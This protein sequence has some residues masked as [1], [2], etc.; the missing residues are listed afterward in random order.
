ML[1]SI[2]MATY[3]GEKYILKQLESIL[4]Q[5]RQP[6]EVIICDDA[7]SDAPT[8]IIRNFIIINQLENWQLEVNKQNVGYRKNFRELIAKAKGDCVFLSD[9]DDEWNEDKI[10][11]MLAVMENNPNI[12]TLNSA[13][14]LIDKT[15]SPIKCRLK[16]NR[17]NCN[18]FRYC[19]KLDKIIF[20]DFHS[21]AQHNVSPGCS[22]CIS[23]RA[24][25]V[26]IALY[27]GEIPHDYFLN[28]IASA[29]NG[30]AF[31]NETLVQYRQ[32]ENNVIGAKSKIKRVR[33]NSVVDLKARL[34]EEKMVAIQ[35]VSSYFDMEYNNQVIAS[36]DFF[37]N[38]F[39]FYQ[40]PSPIKLLKL[41]RT[42]E[43]MQYG[44]AKE[45]L[46]DVAYA[47]H[48]YKPLK[49]LRAKRLICF[50]TRNRNYR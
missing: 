19:G 41:Y 49:L 22:M 7:S 29:N 47:I 15:S 46:V 13:V 1:V 28:L 17:Y 11:R 24:K 44:E 16:K 34:M 39:S 26:F 38:M 12:W 37:H 23:Q 3:N 4:T 33:R 43:Y 18:F 45:K 31:L 20:F 30:C 5:T 21:I 40:N 25:N 35:K 6:D 50:Q 2:V 36:N 10:E 8:E 32:H 9:Q 48:V 14:S 42:V 27:Q